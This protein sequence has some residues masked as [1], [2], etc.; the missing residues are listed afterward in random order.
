MLEPVLSTA[1][2]I[3]V[4][5]LA[6]EGIA[7]CA[8]ALVLLARLVRAWHRTVPKLQGTI[9]NAAQTVIKYS[10]NTRQIAGKVS[11]TTASIRSVPQGFQSGFRYWLRSRRKEAPRD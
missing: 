9:H 8:V 11:G 6:V 10:G 4:I 2:D 5:L 1:R 7:G 3:A